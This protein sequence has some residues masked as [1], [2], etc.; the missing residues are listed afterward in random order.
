[1]F[2]LHGVDPVP[3]PTTN[4]RTLSP[5]PSDP[6]PPPPTPTPTLRR[7]T[8]PHPNPSLTE[9]APALP[10]ASASSWLPSRP[11]SCLGA[12]SASSP[13]S[14]SPTSSPPPSLLRTMAL[15][16]VG[17]PYPTTPSPRL[18]TRLRP[19]WRGCQKPISALQCLHLK[20]RG[21]G[22]QSPLRRITPALAARRGL[23]APPRFF[24]W[25][26]CREGGG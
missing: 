7:T 2:S 25:G 24:L 4:Q 22:D 17:R 10:P 1:M 14:P 5:P 18:P 9:R 19:T 21:T 20:T 23:R 26:H 6:R 15:L 3:R 11:V 8:A 13:S 12:S 16:G